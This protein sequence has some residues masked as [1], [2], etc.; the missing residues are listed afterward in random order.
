MEVVRGRLEDGSP[1]L[2]PLVQAHLLRLF[3]VELKHDRQG[4]EDDRLHDTEQTDAP[5]PIANVAGDREQRIY[6]QRSCE[7]SDNER[8]RHEGPAEGSVAQARGVGHEDVH[9]QVHG[10][11]DD[12]A[13]G[14]T[15]DDE[16][17][18]DG[19]LEHAGDDHGQD[20]GGED[21]R[22]GRKVGVCGRGGLVEDGLL[23]RQHEEAEPNPGEHEDQFHGR[24]DRW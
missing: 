15:P 14:A 21:G 13:F 4:Q 6:G 11:E 2:F 9:D 1:T 10:E 18:S 20:V 12:E 24:L 8:R 17:L 23:E 19:E 3:L 7:R 5:S 16:D 22:R